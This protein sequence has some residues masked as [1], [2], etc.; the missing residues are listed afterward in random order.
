[1]PESERF[2]DEQM[3]AIVEE[4]H[5]LRRELKELQLEMD[6]LH[7]QFRDDDDETAMEIRA[8]RRE[9]DAAAKHSRVL[10]FKLRKAE[11]KVSILK[12]YLVYCLINI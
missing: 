3:K 4:N 1:M 9:L 11:R 5:E 6:E 7:D 2:P 12:I 10:Q 8:L